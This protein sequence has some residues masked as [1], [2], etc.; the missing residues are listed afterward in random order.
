MIKN[1]IKIALRNL[2][3]HKSYSLINISG[4]AVGMACC[5]LIMLWV[6]DELGFDRSYENANN[7]FRVTNEWTDETGGNR[8]A[9][10]PVPLGPALKGQF[11]EIIKATR[12]DN[13]EPQFIKYDGK[14][15]HNDLF[16]LADPDF[17]DMFSISFIQ[18][19]TGSVFDNPS[20]I[21]L[22]RGMSEKYFADDDP[23]GK[24]LNIERRDYTVTGVIEN[25]PANSHIKFDCLAPF[26]SRPQWL[27][28]ITDTWDVS[29]YYTYIQLSE[30]SSQTDVADKISGVLSSNSAS[31]KYEFLLD[32]QPITRI[33]LYHDVTDYL[34]GKGE[35][36]YVYLFS[37]L[38]IMI[39]IIACIN[40]MNLATARSCGRAREIGVRKVIG[41]CRTDIIKQFLGESI[42]TSFTAVLMAIA[43]VELVLPVFNSWSSKQLVLDYFGNS[44][45]ILSLFG[46]TILTGLFA[47]SYPSILLSSFKPIRI[48]K[49]YLNLESGGRKFRKTLV[50]IQFTISIF[51]IVGASVIYSQLHYMRDVNM[52]FD[53]EHLL[54]LRMRGDFYQNYETIKAELLRDPSILAVTAG[55]PPV[56]SFAGAFGLKLD[57]RELSDEIRMASLA[58][59]FDYIKTFS[60]EITQGRDFSGNIAGDKQGG[61]I[62]NETAARILGSDSLIGKQLAFKSH[63]NDLTVSEYSGS[64][65]GIVK[66]FHNGSMHNKIMPVIIYNNP[67][68]IY[69][70]NA[71]IKSTDI[72]AVV[73]LLNE[74]WKSY[75]PQ[76]AFEYHFVDE[77]I[78]SFYRSEQHLGEIFGF[79]TLLAVFVSCLGLFGLV[80]F[81][82][83]Q[84][85][86]E[87]GIRKVL[88]ASL[89]NLMLLLSKDFL[90]LVALANIIAWPLAHFTMSS[91]LESF[92]YRIELG[93]LYFILSGILAFSIA[94]L[95]ISF[96]SIIAANANPVESLRHE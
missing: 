53:K 62:V 8:S 95:T 20:S 1:Y 89:S 69:Y 49:G 2:R 61:F 79:F 78:N 81:S 31:D 50:V 45:I 96:Q 36:K 34:S 22:T 70:M 13:G 58:V 57:T 85:V 56:E 43:L 24:I 76:Y 77:T 59:D 91:W 88:G 19:D 7:L 64:I 6:S 35:I 86:K 65:V 41:A 90:I 82:L 94:F 28:Q 84:R 80:S 4:L 63:G 92:A 72:S 17:F 66:D 74:I 30:T 21:V 55:S 37:T 5:I 68:E 40:F 39:L 26:S 15:F 33:H 83:E 54:Y 11:P 51:L 14:S 75:S 18:G 42:V 93:W 47:G 44:R 52:G 3:N 71:R 16:A 23:I 87:I 29:A 60:M 48:L 67:N 46:I 38:A 10:T 32:L 9:L 73:G 27:R 25:F 12:Y